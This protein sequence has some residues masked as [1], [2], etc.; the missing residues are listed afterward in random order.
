MTTDHIKEHLSGHFTG[1]L[2]SN[3]GYSI[4]KPGT[5]Y[6]IDYQVRKRTIINID[7]NDR[8]LQDGRYI[9][10]QLKCTTENSV[11]I[12]HES[13]KYDLEVKN[14]NDLI[15]RRKEGLVPL[16][17]I[18]FVLPAER[19]NWVNLNDDGVLL[20]RSAYWFRPDIEEDFTQ[21]VSTKRI[22]IPNEN[23]LGVNCFDDFYTEFYP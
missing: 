15:H 6:G 20:G 1:I 3:R 9:D 4:D 13:I 2:A 8:Y 5:D 17:L 18:L 14:Y 23:K 19:S 12:D 22:I 16:V 10:L 11:T 21:N 7:G